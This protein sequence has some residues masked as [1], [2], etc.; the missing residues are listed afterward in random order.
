[1][2]QQTQPR[3]IYALP[4]AMN[5]IARLRAE[6]D[7]LKRKLEREKRIREATQ[8]RIRELNRDLLR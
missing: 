4:A 7:D 1:M 5:Q 3:S 6:I 2:R 8:Q